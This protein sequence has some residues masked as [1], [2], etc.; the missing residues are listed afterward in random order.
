MDASTID[1]M[2]AWERT[3]SAPHC[4]L[5]LLLFGFCVSVRLMS[6]LVVVI[7]EFYGLLFLLIPAPRTLTA[8]NL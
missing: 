8:A 2:I 5:L 6:A 3:L 7:I 4:G 1:C